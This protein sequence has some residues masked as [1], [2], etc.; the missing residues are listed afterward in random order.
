MITKMSIKRIYAIFLR[1]LYLIKSNPTRIASM[2]MWVIIDVIQWGFITRFLSQSGQAVFGFVSAVL[3]AVILW[4]FMARMQNG[5]MMG[6]MED[7]W[8]SNFINLF[9]SPLNIAE[10]LAG[11]VCNGIFLSVMGSVLMVLMAALFFGY[12]IFKIGILLLPAL[13]I[14]FIFAMAMGIFITAVIFKLG[15]SAEWLAWP[16]PLLL[17]IFSGVYYPISTMPVFLQWFAKIIPASYVFESI[18]Y[19]LDTGIFLGQNILIGLGLS[20]VYLA[21]TYWFF[22]KVYKANIKSGRIAKFSAESF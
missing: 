11:L 9:A 12:N 4:E 2:F 20:L 15:P 22:T 21:T 16:I 10:Y 1:Q 7:V 13:L 8:T 17:G 3:G 18:R 5:V 19:I 14:L 6:F